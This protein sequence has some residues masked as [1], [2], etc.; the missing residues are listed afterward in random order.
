MSTVR[1]V[2][3]GI[4]E[5]PL[6]RGCGAVRDG[7]RA[8]VPA[9]PWHVDRFGPGQRSAGV[10]GGADVTGPRVALEQ[11]HSGGAAAQLTEPR[12]GR[13][14]GDL[15]VGDRP[16][17]LPDP[18]TTGVARGAAGRKDVVRADDLVTVGDA[19]ALAEEQRTVVAH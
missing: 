6:V 1:P 7:R 8:V 14:V 2:R 9:S 11:L 4:G 13:G 16:Q 15:L 17:V 18:E 3:L 10:L 19:G 5:V 12:A